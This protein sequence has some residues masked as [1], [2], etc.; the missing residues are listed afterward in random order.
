MATIVSSGYGKIPAR[1]ARRPVARRLPT[2]SCGAHVSHDENCNGCRRALVLSITAREHELRE[3]RTLM[4]APRRV[5][6]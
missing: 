4:G 3:F 2:P 1:G 5:R 6:A